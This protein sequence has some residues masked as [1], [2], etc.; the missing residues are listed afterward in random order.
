MFNATTLMR[1]IS[2]KTRRKL[3][4][5]VR[6]KFCALRG[7]IP[8]ECCPKIDWHHNLIY[9]GRQSDIPNT[10]IGIC[11]NIHDKASRKD[12]K[13]A[14]DRIMYSQMTEED[15]KLLPRLIKKGRR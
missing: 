12:V 3:E 9:A 5:D 8:H 7:I 11:T 2:K 4:E 14:L 15:Y 10:I 1:A 13:E 6:M